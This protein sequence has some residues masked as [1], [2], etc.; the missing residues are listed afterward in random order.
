MNI[1]K[2]DQETLLEKFKSR[3]AAPSQPSRGE[4][5]YTKQLEKNGDNV[6][7]TLRADRGTVNE[8]TALQFLKDEGLNP[9]DYEVVGF[10]KSQ[11]SGFSGEDMES[12][13]YTFKK[14]GSDSD[15]VPLPDLDD[16]HQAVK[17]SRT[18]K[19]QS[20]SKTVG[21][22]EVICL[23]DCQLGKTD[24]LGGTEET[25]QRLE[26]SLE[27]IT[28]R[29]KQSKPEEILLL[30]GGDSIEGFENT[31]AQVQTNDLRL[32][33]MLRVWRRVLWT[34]IDTASSLAPS[35]R[36][37]SVPSNHARVRRGKGYLS[38]PFDD[39]GLEVLAQCFDIAK[40]Y[41]EKYSHVE[42]YT[43]DDHQDTLA[44]QTLDGTVVGLAHGDQVSNPNSLGTWLSG[45]ALQNS[46]VGNCDIL[47]ANH[48]HHL[49]VDIV[50]NNRTIFVT[51]TSDNGSS[52]YTNKSGNSSSPGVMVFS[53][54]KQEI[55][56][57]SGL[58]VL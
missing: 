40:V 42:F 7:A 38:E 35:V 45:Q 20:F 23:A 54:N 51:P 27:S 9:N 10:R 18:K 2:K 47:V 31:A 36:V 8:G 48:F 55:L 24:V 15:R 43:P 22:T 33:E 32:T 34:W 12:V 50:G 37:A 28:A 3:P 53:V 44:L 5:D 13:R 19:E 41:P 21:R 46:P 17:K 29:L 4:V 14:I 49:K 25:L 30:D 58:E 57:W 6:E 26:K 52:W 1:S 39:Y 16:L 11:W 56:G